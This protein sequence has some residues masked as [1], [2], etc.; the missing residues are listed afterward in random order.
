[1]RIKYITT[2]LNLESEEDLSHLATNL[3]HDESPHLNELVNN[4]YKLR[5]GGIGIQNSPVNDIE[6]FCERR[7]SLSVEN[8]ELWNNC[9]SRILDIAFEGGDEP[10]NLTSLLDEGLL[11]RISKLKLGIEITIYSTGLYSH[12]E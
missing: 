5:L 12:L 6:I 8:E 3:C 1:M 11:L 10:N 9:E 2:D 7:E 4:T